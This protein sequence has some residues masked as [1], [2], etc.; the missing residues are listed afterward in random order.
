VELCNRLLGL[1]HAEADAAGKG[2]ELRK[3]LT[4]FA[5][6]GKGYDALVAKAGP[7]A[8]GTFDAKRVASNAAQALGQ[9]PEGT[10]RRMLYE[11]VGFAIF[12]VGAT[13]GYQKETELSAQLAT[14]LKELEPR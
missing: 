8:N 4:S 6:G 14:E 9:A 7:A 12:C 3:G 5:R 10:L 13:L 2:K 11:Y 1:I